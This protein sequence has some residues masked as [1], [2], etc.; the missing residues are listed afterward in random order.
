[1]AEISVVIPVLNESQNVLDVL[2]ALVRQSCVPGEVC[3][4]DA[5]SVDGTP[6]LVRQASK[7]SKYPFA[8][9]VLELKSAFPG[10][11]RNAGVRESRFD[12][13]ACTDAGGVVD[14]QWLARLTAPL[15]DNP[16]VGLV[17]GGF[18]ARGR[19][20]FEH[21]V[22][23]LTVRKT[24]NLALLSAGG[25]SVAFRKSAW[26][27][28]GG[29]AE[30]VYPCED[31]VFL[32]AVLESGIR[33]ERAPE[34]LFYWKP[35]SSLRALARQYH[36]Y[37]WGDATLGVNTRRH[38]LRIMFYLVLLLALLSG[39][40]AWPAQAVV[41]ALLVYLGILSFRGWRQMQ[42]PGAWLWAP[43]IL[44]TKD[45]A[46]IAGWMKGQ[47][48]RLQRGPRNIHGRRTEG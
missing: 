33:I 4:V 43:L 46:Q 2:E 18:E 31:A 26:E 30:D 40:S 34:A 42:W 19:T 28:A 11:G 20:Q 27:K 37:A 29:Y 9:R 25:A 14:P 3:F 5:G 12:T 35:R 38:S 8:V 22:G 21:L 24:A 23:L 32:R 1:M 6:D 15:Q 47:W 7:S 16:T 44:L 36:H 48:N 17:V 45:L 13:I 41:L 10:A 39:L